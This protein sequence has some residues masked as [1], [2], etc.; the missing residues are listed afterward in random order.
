VPYD[1]FSGTR[2]V[3]SA[4]QGQNVLFILKGE[5]AIIKGGLEHVEMIEKVQDELKVVEMEGTKGLFR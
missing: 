2:E 1:W 4:V 3:I 5:V